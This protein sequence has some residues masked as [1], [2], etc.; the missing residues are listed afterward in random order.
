MAFRRIERFKS[1]GVLRL[2]KPVRNDMNRISETTPCPTCGDPIVFIRTKNGK[3]IP[4][5]AFSE[6]VYDP[7]C[8]KRAIIVTWDGK[9]G[10]MGERFT[11]PTKGYKPHWS[12]CPRANDWRT[13]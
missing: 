2:V 3:Q 6:R 5:G 4:C 8:D 12:R 10:A 9:V 1:I 7:V 11:E 13:R